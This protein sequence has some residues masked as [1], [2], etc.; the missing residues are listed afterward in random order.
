M[1]ALRHTYSWA[2]QKTKSPEHR[3]KVACHECIK[4]T[5]LLLGV[6]KYKESTNQRVSSIS[7]HA[8]IKTRLLVGVAKNKESMTKK[9]RN[10]A[11]MH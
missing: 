1:H 3:G 11:S 2:S 6:A 7:R 9:I 10:M 4:Q 5:R 8:C